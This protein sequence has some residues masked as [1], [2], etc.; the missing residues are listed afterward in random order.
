[1]WTA[2]KRSTVAE[3]SASNLL[4]LADVGQ[5]GQYV[6]TVGADLDCCRCERILLHIGEHDGATC[7]RKRMGERQPDA[8]AAARDDRHLAWSDFHSCPHVVID[9]WRT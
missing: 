9:W 6:D 1:M 8:A 4:G 7:C 5:D 3:A 2:P